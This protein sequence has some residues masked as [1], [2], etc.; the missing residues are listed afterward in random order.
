MS[1]ATQPIAATGGVSPDLSV[2]NAALR[3]NL[4][5]SVTVFEA[6]AS[7]RVLRKRS[8]GTEKLMMLAALLAMLAVAML[9]TSPALAQDNPAVVADAKAREGKAGGAP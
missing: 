7:C 8:R 5:H 1:E 6:R 2:E 9:T 4:L 3:S